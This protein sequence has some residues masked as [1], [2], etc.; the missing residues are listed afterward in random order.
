MASTGNKKA[1]NPSIIRQG[2]VVCVGV[3]GIAFRSADQCI[4]QALFSFLLVAS[5]AWGGVQFTWV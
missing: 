1:R 3:S 5:F 4:C 2:G